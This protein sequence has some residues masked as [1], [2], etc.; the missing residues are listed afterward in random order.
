VVLASLPAHL[1]LALA[2]D[3]SPDEAYYLCAVR[4]GRP[5]AD[6][7]PLLLWLLRVS[8]G[9]TSLPVELRVRAWAIGFS[10]ATGFA[11]VALARRRGAPPAGCLLAAWIGTWALLPTAG[12]FIT[13]PDAPF[14]LAV[15]LALLAGERLL[16]AGGILLIGAL[17]KVTA[18]PVAAA[19]TLGRLAAGRSAAPAGRS[20]ADPPPRR[21]PAGARSP[22]LALWWR[23]GALAALAGVV[24]P[25]LLPSLRFQLRH[26]FAQPAPSGWSPLLA[27]GAVA[28]AVS[29]QAGLWSPPVLWRGWRSLPALPAA[30]RA[31]VRVLSALVLISALVRGVPPEPNWWAPAAV[32]VLVAFARTAAELSRRARWAILATVLLPT[33]LAAAH[34]ARP[35]LPLPERLDPTARLHGWSTSREPLAAPGVGVYGA[36]AERCAYR[37][38]CDEISIYFR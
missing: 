8:D 30:D 35:F 34:T 31:L 11:I 24:V 37:G 10:L 14:L 26:A 16:L 18:I 15:T 28:G 5:I 9:W 6:H 29:A 17:A 2:T 13:T 27:L 3:L 4:L 23:L 33:A 20:P 22:S 7:P 25:F 38:H 1:A 12:G 36:A 21:Q 32:V 19:L